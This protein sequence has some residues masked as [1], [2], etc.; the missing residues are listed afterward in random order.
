ME[1]TQLNSQRSLIIALDR[2]YAD[3]L[4][5]KL[6]QSGITEQFTI[7]T[8]QTASGEADSHRT[9]EVLETEQERVWM[10]VAD[11]NMAGSESGA[12]FAIKLLRNHSRLFPQDAEAILFTGSF[13]ASIGNVMHLLAPGRGAYFSLEGDDAAVEKMFQHIYAHAQALLARGT[14][15]ASPAPSAAASEPTS[16][17][18]SGITALEQELAALTPEAQHRYWLHQIL[19]SEQQDSH[20]LG[21]PTPHIDQLGVGPLRHN[22]SPSAENFVQRT[23]ANPDHLRENEE[24]AIRR[25]LQREDIPPKPGGR[26]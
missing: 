15:S 13:K 4:L 20:T 19:R 2:R 7:I 17:P 12:I 6:R 22:L 25:R 11:E 1:H 23:G 8:C 9:H 5:E 16:Q 3:P 21:L 26:S 14:A 10:L 18:A 24:F